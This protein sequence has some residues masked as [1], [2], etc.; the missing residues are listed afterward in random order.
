MTNKRWFYNG[1]INIK[2]GGI[3]YQESGSSDYVNF[4]EVISGTDLEGADNEFMIVSG[5]VW[6]PD[7][8]E[9]RKAALACIGVTSHESNWHVIARACHAYYGIMCDSD[10]AEYKV[11]IGKVDKWQ[12]K[13]W[14]DSKIDIFLRGNSSLRRYVR[15]EHLGLSA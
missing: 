10:Y 3:Y 15:R 11:R 7:D 8:L 2:H 6:I 12:S 5:T 4:V 13:Q 1:D 14:D 9:K